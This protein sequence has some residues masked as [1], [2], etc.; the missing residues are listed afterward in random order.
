MQNL[1]ELT[2]ELTD[3][4][5]MNCLHCSSDSNPNS[6]TY[7]N[8]DIGLRLVEEAAILGAKKINFSG[9]EPTA[10]KLFMTILTRVISL[11][12]SAEIF[13]CGLNRDNQKRFDLSDE[14]IISSQKPNEVKFI[15]SLHGS[16]AESHDYVTQRPGSFEI[17]MK[18]LN[19]CLS[20]GIICEVNFVPMK[21][22]FQEFDK[23]LNLITNLGV[24]KVSILRFVPQGRGYKYQ[25]KLELLRE[26]EDL[27]IKEL[28]QLRKQS[29][30]KIRTGSPFNGI[31]PGN[32]VACRA[33]QGKIVIQPNG[34]VL[35]CEV[36]KHFD[37]CNWGLSVYQKSLS[38]VLKSSQLISFYNSLQHHN[39][40]NCPVHSVLRFYQRAR[41]YYEFSTSSFQS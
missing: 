4:C 20:L 18:S 26:E 11:G 38:E 35:P 31:I 13:T 9:G 15:F 34:N 5:P 2:L 19:R 40:L 28:N 22:N 14:I 16:T 27:F 39:C 10:S 8:P 41:G 29:L 25:H 36:F 23:I 37:R 21:I 7:L 24:N 1:E 3:W 12:M 17:L 6:N 30:V 32:R 33:G